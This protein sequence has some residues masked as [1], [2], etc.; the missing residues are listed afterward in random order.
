ME[1]THSIQRGQCVVLTGDLLLFGVGF[2]T[3][4]VRPNTLAARVLFIFGAVSLAIGISGLLPD[5]VTVMFEPVAFY[6]SSF[7]VM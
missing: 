7:L 3:L 2:F 1:C 4:V 6:G 5:G